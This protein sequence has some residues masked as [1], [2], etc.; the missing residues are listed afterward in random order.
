MNRRLSLPILVV[1]IA[2]VVAVFV[3]TS[4][5]STKKVQPAGS[6][7]SLTQTSVGRTLAD[8]N[9]RTL[10]LFAS[11]KPGVSTLSAA[12]RAVWPPFTA[13]TRPLATGGAAAGLIGT[14]SATGQV[15][16]NGHPLYYFVGDK[17]P[18]ELS[19][20]GLNEFG[21]RWYVLSSSGS[22]I[23]SAAK[24]A[25]PSAPASTGSGS[26]AGYGY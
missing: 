15:T 24:S 23:T 17:S 6:S 12:G 19:G 13:T 10:Y 26:G 14:V 4:G 20:Q 18:G 8:A 7:I 21:A 1:I 5:G 22:A 3:S 25:A 16:Y 2:A 9:G 11:D